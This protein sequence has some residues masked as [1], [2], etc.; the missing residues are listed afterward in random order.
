MTY[1]NDIALVKIKATSA[2]ATVSQ[3]QSALEK[4]GSIYIYKNTYLHILRYKHIYLYMNIYTNMYMTYMNDIVLAKTKA[5]SAS[6]PMSRLQSALEKVCHIYTCIYSY[7]HLYIYIYIYIY[8]YIYIYLYVN[9]IHER[10]RP[11]QDKSH[12]RF[13]NYESTPVCP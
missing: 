2:A 10:Y 13:S 9:N 3:F 1:L 4:V 5:T 8:T 7:T 11:R 12:F 6:S